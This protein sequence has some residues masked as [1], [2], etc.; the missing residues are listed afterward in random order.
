VQNAG[1]LNSVF[2]N[3]ID[4]QPGQTRENQLASSRLPAWATYMGKLFR[5]FQPLIN[6]QRDP[7]SH[8][9]TNDDEE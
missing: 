3:P 5:R 6:P 4:S 8:P 9:G 2:A 7:A 1:Y